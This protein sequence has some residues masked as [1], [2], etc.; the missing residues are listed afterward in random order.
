VFGKLAMDSHIMRLWV[1]TIAPW[2]QHTLPT[3]QFDLLIFALRGVS[4]VMI[5]LTNIIMINLFVR[6]M[7][8]STTTEAVVVNTASNFFFTVRFKPG[9][10]Q[11][12]LRQEA[13][14]FF[15]TLY[16]V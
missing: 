5:F 6:S 2:L 11:T 1:V 3:S 14:F 12:P 10:S 13:G 9:R 4:F 8:L 7:N 15:S 16:E